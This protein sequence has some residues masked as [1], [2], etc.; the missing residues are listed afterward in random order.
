MTVE[1]GL[2][3]N[4]QRLVNELFTALDTPGEVGASRLS[5]LFCEEGKAIV[6]LGTLTG[7]KGRY[8]SITLLVAQSEKI[9]S[10]EAADNMSEIYQ[11]R[12]GAWES[13]EYRRH[14]VSRVYSNSDGCEDLILIGELHQRV[15][16]SEMEKEEWA[17]RIMLDMGVPS[18][19]KVSLYQVWRVC[20]ITPC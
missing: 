20:T 17:A 2:P 5:G 16:G 1:D 14:I 9:V 18:Q 11:R 15:K 19:P 6:P 13:V 12:V 8:P 7:A 3:D 4:I 10:E